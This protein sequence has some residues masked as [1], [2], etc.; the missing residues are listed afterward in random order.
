MKLACSASDFFFFSWFHYYFHFLFLLFFCYVSFFLFLFHPIK[1]SVFF[2]RVLGANPT[3]PTCPVRASP[4][5]LWAD[6]SH[7]LRSFFFFFFFFVLFFQRGQ[8]ELRTAQSDP[9][10]GV[11][12]P[13]LP[14]SVPLLLLLLLTSLDVTDGEE[15]TTQ[16]WGE[17]EEKKKG[18]GQT[19]T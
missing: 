1:I 2:E 9:R 6:V 10:A 8:P 17:I 5:L 3:P 7:A 14:P 11:P 16:K 4:A 13:F 15:W 18:N 19:F 12:P